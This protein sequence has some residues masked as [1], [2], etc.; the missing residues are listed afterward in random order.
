MKDITHTYINN[1]CIVGIGL[2]IEGILLW[3]VPILVFNFW[4]NYGWAL[5]KNI[6]SISTMFVAIG[7]VIGLYSS[8]YLINK[9]VNY[10]IFEKNNLEKFFKIILFLFPLIVIFSALVIKYLIIFPMTYKQTE[11][12]ILISILSYGGGVCFSM[13]YNVLKIFIKNI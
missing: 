9:D 5:L 12:M 8:K 1:P 6:F 10:V 13:G 4:L 7:I 3:I 2:M 11:S